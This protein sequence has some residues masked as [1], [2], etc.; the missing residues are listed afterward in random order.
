MEAVLKDEAA[1][2][3]NISQAV[4]RLSKGVDGYA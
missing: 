4:G 1:G 3:Y 2:G